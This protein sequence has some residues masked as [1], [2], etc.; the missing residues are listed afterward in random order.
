MAKN[1]YVLNSKIDLM[2]MFVDTPASLIN[3]VAIHETSSNMRK[4]N[5]MHIFF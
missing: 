1:N 4:N 3:F 5:L 2:R